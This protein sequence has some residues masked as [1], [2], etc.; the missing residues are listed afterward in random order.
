MRCSC[1]LCGTYMI[2]A[3]SSVLGCVCPDCG[4]RCRDCLGTDSV[5]SR[6]QLA[7]LKENPALAAMF[8]AQRDD[9]EEE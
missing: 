6:E 2:Q 4:N 1:R 8:M 5:M 9:G 3:D 7:E